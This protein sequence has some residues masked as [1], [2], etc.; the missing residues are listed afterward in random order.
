MVQVT[1]N[2]PDI[3]NVYLLDCVCFNFYGK[4]SITME[5]YSV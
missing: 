4:Q 2:N 3:K 5:P 1:C